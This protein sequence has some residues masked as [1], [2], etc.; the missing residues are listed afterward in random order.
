M[1]I[2]LISFDFWNY[3]E[4]IVEKLSDKGIEACHINIGA[5][6]H[7]NT[8][9]RIKNT[10]SKIFLG[11]NPKYHKRQSFILESLEK[12]GR[13][14]QILVINPEAIDESIHQKI[15]EYTDRNIAYLYDSMA[16]NP[17]THLLH[18]FDTIFSFDDED[19]KNFGFEKITNYNYLDHIPASKQRPKLDLFYITSY[20]QKRLSALN[21]LINRIHPMKIK[22]E[23]YMVGKKGWKNK[24]NQIIDKKNIDILKFGR[25][26]IPHHVLPAYYKNTKV[27]LD[28]MRADQTGLSFRIFEAMALE[29]KIITDNP[30]I[31]TYDF[32]N[33]NNILVL[34]KNFRNLK[35]D[36]FT[37]PYEKLSEEVYYKYTLDH[38]VNTVFKLNS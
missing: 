15:R 3:D 37:T 18:Y 33:P 9:E 13:Q 5:F 24:L 31:K 20:D 12:I 2:C 7:K 4:H 23:V 30:T 8:G 10:F 28:L 6:T 19:V 25:K 35:K 14:D 11:K 17:A 27:I 32:Y 21:M 38:W 29:K 22:F 26:K 36:F 16:R 1:K 34:D